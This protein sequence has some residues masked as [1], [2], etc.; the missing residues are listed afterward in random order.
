MEDDSL[1]NHGS[2]LA[3]S[4][5]SFSCQ[6]FVTMLRK[7]TN[8]TV[9]SW[10]SS[11]SFRK[12]VGSKGPASPRGQLSNIN[13]EKESGISLDSNCWTWM[14]TKFI[15]DM[16]LQKLCRNLLGYYVYP[17]FFLY[18]KLSPWLHEFEARAL[19]L[20]HS[21]N[22][23]PWFCSQKLERGPGKAALTIPSLP[24]CFH[25]CV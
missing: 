23:F 25:H 3:A 12:L 13:T 17:L 4:Q 19:F 11:V 10:S 20:S 7:V 24:A 6:V 18:W 1:W 22:S 5:A 2:N 8:R 9:K 14:L 16:L 21:C 15:K